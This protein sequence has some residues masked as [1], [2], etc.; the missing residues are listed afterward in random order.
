MKTNDS[1]KQ[2]VYLSMLREMGASLEKKI[3]VKSK[4]DQIKSIGLWLSEDEAIATGLPLFKT[5]GKTFPQ[6]YLSKTQCKSIKIPVVSNEEPVA[7]K[8]NNIRNQY[9]PLYDRSNAYMG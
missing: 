9:F 8:R 1:E 7:Y 4:D 2:Q 3:P 6:T 5:Y